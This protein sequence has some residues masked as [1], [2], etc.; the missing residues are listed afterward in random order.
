MISHGDYRTAERQWTRNRDLG[1]RDLGKVAGPK[2]TQSP[3]VQELDLIET[4]GV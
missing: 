2:R 3:T 4:I 1:N